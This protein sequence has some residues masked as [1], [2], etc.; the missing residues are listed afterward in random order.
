MSAAGVPPAQN[1]GA[2]KSQ[3][4]A[5]AGAA[6]F[7][8]AL[9]YSMSGPISF[10]YNNSTPPGRPTAFS[11]LVRSVHA[12]PRRPRGVEGSARDLS[13]ICVGGAQVL[14][15]VQE[16][17]RTFVLAVLRLGLSTCLLLFDA[18]LRKASRSV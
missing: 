15:V 7:P 16:I 10:A 14:G 18:F 12:A 8:G 2:S 5:L 3:T 1:R 11:K 9:C 17:F 6:S 4:S 13:H